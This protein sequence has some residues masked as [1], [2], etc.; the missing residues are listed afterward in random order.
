M[1]TAKKKK[2]FKKRTAQDFILF[3]NWWL[4]CVISPKKTL[5]GCLSHLGNSLEKYRNRT[6]KPVLYEEIP[7]G[8]LSG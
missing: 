5:S 1:T 6:H 2:L 8:D 3:L 7:F 4:L